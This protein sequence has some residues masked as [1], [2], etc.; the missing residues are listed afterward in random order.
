M[1][2]LGVVVTALAVLF[3]LTALAFASSGRLGQPYRVG[4][5]LA[6]ALAVG[7]ALLLLE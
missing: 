5:A 4:A 7:L 2:L 1:L 6:T 3:S